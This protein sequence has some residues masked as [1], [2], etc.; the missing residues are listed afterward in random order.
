MLHER[1]GGQTCFK[2][3]NFLTLSISEHFPFPLSLSPSKYVPCP[4]R[5]AYHSNEHPR[6]GKKVS[7]KEICSP[8]PPSNNSPLYHSYSVVSL[9][10]MYFKN[11]VLFVFE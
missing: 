9:H 6:S 2:Q 10:I 1:G 5:N 4:A 7:Y 8:R 3:H 11:C